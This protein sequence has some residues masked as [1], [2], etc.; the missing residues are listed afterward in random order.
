MEHAHSEVIAADPVLVF[1]TVADFST[2][3]EWQGPVRSVDVRSD[4]VVAFEID[5]K[6]RTIRYTLR[7]HLEP[8]KRIWWEL[9]EG[10]PKHVSGEYTFEDLGDGST[11]ATYRLDI[12]PGGFVPGPV[13]KVLRDQVMKGSVADLKREV[14]RRAGA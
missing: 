13:K 4:G 14:E 10:D 3:A 5:V 6:V 11:R 1:D 9:V 7:Y 12:D 2:Y 8:P